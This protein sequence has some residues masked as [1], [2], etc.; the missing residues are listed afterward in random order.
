MV[1]GLCSAVLLA[2]GLRGG[3]PLLI[4]YYLTIP[5]GSWSLYLRHSSVINIVKPHLPIC[6]SEEAHGLPLV[7][8]PRIIL[9]DLKFIVEI[10]KHVSARHLRITVKFVGLWAVVL[11]GVRRHRVQ[12]QLHEILMLLL[13]ERL[14]HD[15]ETLVIWVPASQIRVERLYELATSI[16]LLDLTSRLPYPVMPVII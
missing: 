1:P 5:H 9:R 6:F 12:R 8:P 14:P 4:L 2:G 11:L 15:R 7:V 10:G 16:T 3:G 13:R